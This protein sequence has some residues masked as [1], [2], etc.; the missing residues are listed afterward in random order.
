MGAERGSLRGAGAHVKIDLAPMTTEATVCT[1]CGAPDDG[2]EVLCHYCNSPI[3]PEVQAGAIPCGQCNHLNRAGRQ[4]CSRCSAWIVVECVF[5]G[6]LSPRTCT[7]CTRCNEPFAGAWERKQ[8]RETQQQTQVVEEVLGDVA[9]IAGAVL[10]GG[11]R[12]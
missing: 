5:C 7:A 1:S 8:Q 6:G 11:R 12:P 10:L 2:Q 4:Q 9:A 3:S